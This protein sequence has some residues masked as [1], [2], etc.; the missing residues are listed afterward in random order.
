MRKVVVSEFVTLDGI[1]EA[2]EEWSLAFWDDEIAQLKQDELFNSDALLLGRITYEG[3]AEA[4]P[5]RSGDAYS[6]RMNSLPKYVVS[7]TLEKPEWNNSTVIRSNV[8]EEI[9]RLKQ[10]GGQ[11]I[12]VFGSTELIETLMAND[13]ID[14]YR[15]MVY[16]VVR[17]EGKRLFADGNEASLTIKKTQEFDS[18]VVL[19][20]YQPVQ[21]K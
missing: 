13:L 12:L 9:S 1:T 15:L 16:P 8:V 14:E 20:S 17:G 6:D 21:N 10:E 19:L 18:G 11:D 2:P 5:S 3:F 4:W 7:T